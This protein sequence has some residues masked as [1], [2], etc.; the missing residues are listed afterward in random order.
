MLCFQGGVNRFGGGHKRGCS[1]ESMYLTLWVR[2]TWRNIFCSRNPSK[3]FPGMSCMQKYQCNC[4]GLIRSELKMLPEWPLSWKKIIMPR[5]RSDRSCSEIRSIEIWMKPCSIFC[6][7]STPNLFMYCLLWYLLQLYIYRSFPTHD[8][9]SFKHAFSNTFSQSE[10]WAPFRVQYPTSLMIN[11]SITILSC[12]GLLDTKWRCRST[13][14]WNPVMPFISKTQTCS[15]P[16]CAFLSL[17]ILK[18][19]LSDMLT[20]LYQ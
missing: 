6:N 4:N 14:S 15:F 7:K 1:K 10:Q 20:I 18:N 12:E 9:G 2:K 8:F 13:W 16:A 11:N 5:G 19:N 17:D 3:S